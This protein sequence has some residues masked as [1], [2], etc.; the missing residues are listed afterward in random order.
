MNQAP[1]KEIAL[2]AALSP[3]E[4]ESTAVP[5]DRGGEG[6]RGGGGFSYVSFWA[7]TGAAG[8][9]KVGDKVGHKVETKCFLASDYS[10]SNVSS[11]VEREPLV[12]GMWR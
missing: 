5:Q 11:A 6:G 8:G 4:G 9:D 7:A 1:D 2:T 10:R 12:S 3:G